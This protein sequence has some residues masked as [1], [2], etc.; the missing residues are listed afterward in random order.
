MRSYT[1][2]HTLPSVSHTCIH[3]CKL[4][5]T[6]VE[7]GKYTE[8][9]T[10]SLDHLE[11]FPDGHVGTNYAL[12]R[13]SAKAGRGEGLCVLLLSHGT[14]ATMC[15]TC[16]GPQKRTRAWVKRVGNPDLVETKCNKQ[17][18]IMRHEC[19]ISSTF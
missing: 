13:P 5:P 6:V 12:R 3:K 15:S 9:Q 1:C 8:L 10:H 16:V 19:T 7:T 17:G 11:R 4:I 2:V 18:S 14:G